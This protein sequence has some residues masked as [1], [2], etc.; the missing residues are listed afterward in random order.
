[1]LGW[2]MAGSREEGAVQENS[3]ILCFANGENRAPLSEIG[4]ILGKELVMWGII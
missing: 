2:L 3:V 1:M 4:T